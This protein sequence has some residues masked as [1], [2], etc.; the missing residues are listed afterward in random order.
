MMELC[1]KLNQLAAGGEA[2]DDRSSV[3]PQFLQCGIII[4]QSRIL[5]NEKQQNILVKDVIPQK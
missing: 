5:E 2:Q 3:G 4:C 1:Q